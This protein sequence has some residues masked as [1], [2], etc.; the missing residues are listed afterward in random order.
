MIRFPARLA[1][2]LIFSCAIAAPSR[3]QI[4]PNGGPISYSAD[5]LDYS[6]RDR[7]LTLTGNVDVIQGDA[8]LQ[9]DTLILFMR[10]KAPEGAQELGVADIQKIEARGDVH[11]VRPD[12]KVRG[13]EAIY[14]AVSDTVTFTGNVVV[15]NRDIVTRAEILVLEIGTGLARLNPNPKPGQR[16][17]GQIS[18]SAA[19]GAER[20]GPPDPPR[21]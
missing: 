11:L 20:A 7:Q 17:Q 18:A 12:Q 3:A 4:S 10:P 9:A 1:A 21:Q 15:A 8:R 2:I 19:Q 13:D 5:F 6:D 16:V 14:D